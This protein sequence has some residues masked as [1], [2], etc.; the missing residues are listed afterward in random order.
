MNI[1]KLIRI[2]KEY[3]IS[4]ITITNDDQDIHVQVE[5]YQRKKA[6]CSHCGKIHKDNPRGSKTIT[7]RD[8]PVTG[9]KVYLHIKRRRY[10]CSEDGRLHIETVDWIKKKAE[11]PRGMHM[12]YIG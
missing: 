3:K 5:P 9:R 7:V 6:I 4:D 1:K 11:V 2:P 12:R 10:R 8:L